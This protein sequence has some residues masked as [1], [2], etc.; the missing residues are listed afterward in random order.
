MFY[1]AFGFIEHFEN[2]SSEQQSI[3]ST[4]QINIKSSQQSIGS[5]EQQSIGSSG[6]Q[7]IGSSGQQSARF[8]IYKS[9]LP[10]Q[11]I[12]S[13]NQQSSRSTNQQ[14]SGSTN[15][16]SSGS[17]NQQSSGSTNQ[18][19]SGSTNQQSSGSTNQQSSESTNNL[20]DNYQIGFT[21]TNTLI[22]QNILQFKNNL[23]FETYNMSIV[24]DSNI[25]KFINNTIGIQ[26]D[27]I[28]DLTYSLVGSYVPFITT[29]INYNLN[30]KKNKIIFKYKDQYNYN[31]NLISDELIDDGLY[32]IIYLPIQKKID[33]SQINA[34]ILNTYNYTNGKIFSLDNDVIFTLPYNKLY[35]IYIFPM[36]NINLTFNYFENNTSNFSLEPNIYYYI[37]YNINNQE[38]IKI[39]EL[40][41]V[42]LNLITSPIPIKLQDNSNLLYY[43]NFLNFNENKF[44]NII[45]KKYDTIVMNCNDCTNNIK[46]YGSRY[47]NASY[48]GTND[49]YIQLPDL[50]L[51]NKIISFSIN[52]KT[53]NSGKQVLFDIGYISKDY[54]YITSVFI[55]FEND[56]V[57]FNYTKNNELLSTF[58]YAEGSPKLN[59][60]EWHNIIWTLN[61]NKWIIYVDSIKILNAT[62]FTPNNDSFNCTSDNS[63]IGKKNNNN[64]LFQQYDNF[65]GFIDNFKIYNKELLTLEIQSENIK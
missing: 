35:E 22:S 51:S 7:S 19:S 44:Y 23:N 13:T 45:N 42:N 39:I 4:N 57:R 25:K 54:K 9:S 31:I 49:V 21:Q 47:S 34:T 38:P 50:N 48:Y 17:T 16:Q 2:I 5:S 30:L 15:Q 29:I 40:N 20:E 58:L 10:S 62:K 46:E 55:H 41:I 61:N 56:T 14:S 24:D 8:S 11:N 26:M 12:K 1:N 6:Q 27:T 64:Q 63:F 53:I 37:Y 43:N 52:F 32:N 33:I 65:I 60:N 28:F 3:D 59:D 18:Q 36:K